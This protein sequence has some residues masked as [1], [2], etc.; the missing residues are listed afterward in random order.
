M[1]GCSTPAQAQEFGKV[2]VPLFKQLAKC[3]NSSHFQVRWN[4]N[5]EC[6]SPGGA[7]GS[8]NECYWFSCSQEALLSCL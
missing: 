6:K 3:L 2:L 7:S 5:F 8:V 4:T 1:K